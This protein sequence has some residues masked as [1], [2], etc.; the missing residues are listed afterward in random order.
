MS[1]LAEIE[2]KHHSLYRFYDEAGILLYVGISV[3]PLGRWDQ[4][5]TKTWWRDVRTATIEP[6]E[7]R[8]AALDAELAAIRA[9]NPQHNIRRGAVMRAIAVRVDDALW[10]AAGA[11]SA[12]RD[13]TISGVIKRL[14]AEYVEQHATDAD[15][16]AARDAR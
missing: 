8:E 3:N 5:R 13:E 4:H 11:I 2:T 9:E 6:C 14:L 7:S 12:S 15:R 16:A 1:D 10:N